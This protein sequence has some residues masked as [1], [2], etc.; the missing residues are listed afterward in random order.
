M[1]IISDLITG[2]LDNVLAAIE[3]QPDNLFRGIL[4]DPE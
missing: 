2:I 1:D 3:E 4:G